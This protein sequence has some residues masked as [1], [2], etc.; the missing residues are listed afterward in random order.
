MRIRWWGW[1]LAVA[2]LL[3]AGLIAPILIGLVG[4]TS[5]TALGK[6]AGFLKPI[7]LPTDPR[8][9]MR[10]D[11]AGDATEAYRKALA[12]Y[13]KNTWTY[14]EFAAGEAAAPSGIHELLNAMTASTATLF[15]DQPAVLINYQLEKPP[16]EMLVKLGRLLNRAGLLRT[17]HSPDE[18]AQYHRAAFALGEKLYAERLDYAELSA[19]L[20]LMSESATALHRLA[21]KRGD[22]DAQRRL[23]E[24]L[25][26]TRSYIASHLL[27][28]QRILSTI[29]PKTIE[30]HAGDVYLLAGRSQERMW[31]VE[32]ILAL[33]RARFNAARAGDQRQANRY[34]KE[35][36]ADPNLDPIFRAAVEAAMNLTAEEYRGL[37]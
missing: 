35:L 31:R 19:G 32:A 3:A 18:A 12:D 23:D 24:F 16:L 2:A 10:I 26:S 11:P 20:G 37:Q 17:G 1:S 22:P 15:A 13:Q 6:E 5:P 25:Q 9:L 30:Q 21:E 33:G 4:T 29:D 28:K 14:E 27:P 36:S 8:T 7:S 34:L